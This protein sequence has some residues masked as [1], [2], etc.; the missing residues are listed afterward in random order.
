MGRSTSRKHIFILIYQLQFHN[1][2]E[3]SFLSENYLKE[4]EEIENITNKDKQFILDELNG[5]M[6]NLVEIDRLISEN[7]VRW[8]IERI[9]KIDLCLLRLAI[10]EMKFSKDIPVSVAI[11]EAVNL[12]REYSGDDSPSFINGLLGKVSKL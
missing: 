9:N 4:I 8:T 2:D 5:T 12:A 7:L 10:Y 6:K 3:L 1:I 11:N